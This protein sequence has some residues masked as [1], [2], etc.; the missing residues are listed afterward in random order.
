MP[1]WFSPQ[2]RLLVC[3]LPSTTPVAELKEYVQGELGDRIRR[4]E[5]DMDYP[6]TNVL[7]WETGRRVEVEDQNAERALCGMRS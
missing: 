3:L 2:A 6:G 7:V 4:L 5:V 1:R